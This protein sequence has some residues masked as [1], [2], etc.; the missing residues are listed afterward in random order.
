[1]GAKVTHKRIKEKYSRTPNAREREHHERVMQEPCAA[2]GI[3][4]C[5]VAH[6]LMQDAPDKRWRRD[7]Q[8]TVPLCDPCHRALH[9]H[10]GEAKWSLENG[11]NAVHVA[12]FERLVSQQEGI[13]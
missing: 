9:A 10:G 1:M 11:F 6:H 2:C 3:R 13:L 7:H 8:F 12:R 4:P 5:G